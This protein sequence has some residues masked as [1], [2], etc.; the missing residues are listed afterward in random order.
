MKKDCRRKIAT[1][2]A[3]EVNE[4]AIKTSS[5]SG[6][7]VGRSAEQRNDEKQ[8][9]KNKFVRI[10]QFPGLE[11][12][13]RRHR[14]KRA[15]RK[16][17]QIKSFLLCQSKKNSILSFSQQKQANIFINEKCTIE[18]FRSAEKKIVCEAGKSSPDPSA[19]RS[20]F[21]NGLKSSRESERRVRVGDERELQKIFLARRE[22]ES[23]NRTYSNN[24]TSHITFH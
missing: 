7:R 2:N 16:Y 11:W 24:S 14:K 17:Y 21:G 15:D 12:A 5:E 4:R 19:F 9:K 8:K 3:D 6:Q 10:N 22:N 18:N 20:A 13:E 1:I 23:Y